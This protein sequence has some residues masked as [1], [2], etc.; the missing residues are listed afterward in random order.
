MAG[1]SDFSAA[2]IRYFN[3]SRRRKCHCTFYL[4][5]ILER[6]IMKT[7]TTKSTIL[8]ISMG[9][10]ILYLVF[11]WQWAVVVSLTIGLIGIISTTLSR[12]IE[13]GWMKMERILSYIVPSVILGI[14]FYL[15]LFPLSLVSKLFVKD[16]LMLSDKYNTYFVTSE[17]DI[18]RSSIEKL[19]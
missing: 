2:R 13:W 18:D 8:V 7:D 14:I 15:L 16:P 4:Y 3:C 19:W 1:T 17:K 12:K 9:F 5:F 6:L 10:L 11:A